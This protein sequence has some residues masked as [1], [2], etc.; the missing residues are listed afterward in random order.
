MVLYEL[1]VDAQERASLPSNG[2][3]YPRVS[4][5]KSVWYIRRSWMVLVIRPHASI[6][7]LEQGK[8]VAS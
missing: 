2:L 4:V 6:L 1:F 7:S 8:E 3:N 5:S